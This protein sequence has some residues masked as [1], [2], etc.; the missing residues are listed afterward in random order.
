MISWVENGDPH[1]RSVLK[2]LKSAAAG[3]RVIGLT[4]S[5]GA[6]KSTVTSALVRAFRARGQSVAVLAVDPS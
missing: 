5:P 2:D 3:T 4:G 1:I 6:G